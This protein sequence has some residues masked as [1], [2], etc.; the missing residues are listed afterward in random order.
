MSIE[1]ISSLHF[2]K[3]DVVVKD[4]LPR[5]K[6]VRHVPDEPVKIV[7]RIPDEPVKEIMVTPEEIA[8]E[9]GVRKPSQ[10][11]ILK[12]TDSGVVEGALVDVLLEEEKK[13]SEFVSRFLWFAT[14]DYYLSNDDTERIK[15]E[16]NAVDKESADIDGLPTSHTCEKTIK[17]PAAA[18]NGDKETLRKKLLQ[19]IELSPKQGFDMA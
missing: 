4:V 11:A 19:S 9:H 3:Q 16:F 1:A 18:Y 12:I 7:M 17:L 6:I 14:G 8:M 2:S 5:L 13:D 10:D 15:V